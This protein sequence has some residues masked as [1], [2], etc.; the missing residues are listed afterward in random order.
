[1]QNWGYT[2]HIIEGT[3]NIYPAIS[4]ADLDEDGNIE[5]L[6][7]TV[8]KLYAWKNDGTSFWPGMDYVPIEGEHA[9]GLCP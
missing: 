8:G 7:F 9:D 5:V 1:M 6:L 2:G 4:L 3:R